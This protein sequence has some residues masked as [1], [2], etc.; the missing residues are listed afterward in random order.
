MVEIK[1]WTVV[2]ETVNMQ[3]EELEE[4]VDIIKKEVTDQ[5]AANMT[6]G[7]TRSQSPPPQTQPS[8]PL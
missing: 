5:G 6:V 8:V 2:P 1:L 7:S 3:S 4:E